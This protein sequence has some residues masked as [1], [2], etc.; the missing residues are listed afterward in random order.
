MEAEFNINPK[1]IKTNNKTSITL[2]SNNYYIS[3]IKSLT[4]KINNEIENIT[5][6]DEQN[7]TS[8]KFNLT[9]QKE[10]T[11]QIIYIDDEDVS[12][13]KYIIKTKF[14]YHLEK[15]VY[16]LSSNVKQGFISFSLIVGDSHYDQK[17]ECEPVCSC[18]DQDGQ[19]FQCNLTIDTSPIN[20][21]ITFDDDHFILY[22][23]SYEIDKKENYI[24][25]EGNND[26]I[27]II[28]Y[29]F[30]ELDDKYF[31]IQINSHIQESIKE[32]TNKTK[33]IVTINNFNNLTLGTY[34]LILFANN[35]NE[36]K[37]DIKFNIIKNEIISYLDHIPNSGKQTIKITTNNK[38]QTIYINKIILKKNSEE[39]IESEEC[40][41][42]KE[43]EY[44]LKCEIN[45]ISKIKEEEEKEEEEEE[46][47]NQK[48]DIYFKNICGKEINSNRSLY[49]GKIT[50]E[51]FNPE[52]YKL[53]TENQEFVLT[54]TPLINDI[55]NLKIGLKNSTQQFNI[56]KKDE[57]KY[58]YIE[59]SPEFN[60]T[61]NSYNLSIIDNETEYSS[62]I[63]LLLYEN[64]IELSSN[65][66]YLFKGE[67]LSYKIYLKKEIF[68]E[69]ITSIK[70][71][72]EVIKYGTSKEDE[73]YYILIHNFTFVGNSTFI[74][75]QKG[76]EQSI[77][78][79]LYEINY[80]PTF[81]V[82]EKKESSSITIDYEI[83]DELKNFS[84]KDEN[85]TIYNGTCV[86]Y[87]NSIRCTYN[88]DIN[89][90]N[91]KLFVGQAGESSQDFITVHP[92]LN[93]TEVCQDMDNINIT[94]EINNTFRD[95]LILYLNDNAFNSTPEIKP[96]IFTFNKS[97]SLP[98]DDYP[99]YA[100]INNENNKYKIGDNYT[101]SLYKKREIDFTNKTLYTRHEQSLKIEFGEN[102]YND[103][104]KS[105][106][107][108]S[109]DSN[110]LIESSNC[111]IDSENKT[112]F[113][114]FDLFNT[115][116]GNYNVY[117]NAKC[118]EHQ[119][120]S[121]ENTT[122]K[123]ENAILNIIIKS[124]ENNWFKNDTKNQTITIYYEN[125]NE[126]EILIDKVLLINKNTSQNYT[127]DALQIGNNILF[128][129]S[130]SENLKEDTYSII[131]KS[132]NDQSLPS[133][134]DN[135][136]YIY[137]EPFFTLK[138]LYYIKTNNQTIK[139]NTNSNID[140]IKKMYL[141]ENNTFIQKDKEFSLNVSELNVSELNVSEFIITPYFTIKGDSLNKTYY[142]NSTKD[143]NI[144]I[145][146]Y[147]NESELYEISNN[148]CNYYNDTDFSVK[149]K[150]N[151]SNFPITKMKIYL[152]NEKNNKSIELKE[153]KNNEYE[154]EYTY[155][156]KKDLSDLNNT[157]VKLIISEN[158]DI[159]YYISQK[160]IS[161]TDFTYDN[162]LEYL[163]D[164]DSFII[165]NLTCNLSTA[166]I[167][168]EKENQS[169]SIKLIFES[170]DKN[171]ATY[172]F[173][174]LSADSY[175]LG[176]LKIYN[177]VSN[178]FL[179]KI[180]N[181]SKFD[182]TLPSDLSLSNLEI[183]I[184]N[185]N[186][187]F[188]NELIKEIRITKKGDN[189]TFIYSKDS[190]DT[191][192][193]LNDNIFNFTIKNYNQGDIYIIN[194]IGIDKENKKEFTENNIIG[195][196]FTIPLP[197]YIFKNGENISVS[198]IILHF[199][200]KKDAESNLNKIKIDNK[201]IKN[202]KI[203]EENVTCEYQFEVECKEHNVT[204]EDNEVKVY[205]SIYDILEGFCQTLYDDKTKNKN[206][207]ILI[208]NP[209]PSIIFTI[210]YNNNNYELIENKY[211]IP[212][213]D[214]DSSNTSINIKYNDIVIKNSNDNLT[215]YDF[216]KIDEIEGNLVN[217]TISSINLTFSN[218]TKLEKYYI[219]YNDSKQE[220]YLKSSSFTKFENSSKYNLTFN[221]SSITIK[222]GEYDLC[223]I[224]DCENY[225]KAKR[226]IILSDQIDASMN[227]NYIIYE[228]DKNKT[229]SI[230]ISGVSKDLI[231]VYYNNEKKL[232][233]S[234]STELY[235]Y[236]EYK[237][238]NI[239]NVKFYYKLN[240]IKENI[241][242]LKVVNNYSDL[243]KF[244]NEIPQCSYKNDDLDLV[245]TLTKVGEFSFNS[246]EM[247][248]IKTSEK[249]I[250]FEKNNNV[251]T[252]KKD[253]IKSL[254]KNGNYKIIITENK[255][256]NDVLYSTN[257]E[258][259][260]IIGE[261]YYYKNEIEFREVNCKPEIKAIFNLDNNNDEISYNLLCNDI[262]DNILK[263]NL[264]ND[265]NFG[266]YSFIS[267]DKKIIDSLISNSL[268]E[269]DF[270]VQSK[271][272][273]TFIFT[274]TNNFYFKE[275]QSLTVSQNNSKSNEF[276]KGINLTVEDEFI[277][278][279]LDTSNI[280]ISYTITKIQT[281]KGY[282]IIKIE[283]LSNQYQIIIEKDAFF[284]TYN[285]DIEDEVTIKFKPDL[286]TNA[287]NQI[288]INNIDSE[289]ERNNSSK[290]LICKFTLPN[291]PR[292]FDV[293]FVTTQ[294]KSSATIYINGYDL[295]IYDCKKPKINL[296]IEAPLNLYDLELCVDEKDI[297]DE[298]IITK[299]LKNKI[300][301]FDV[302]VDSYSTN[303]SIKIN[304]KYILD[305]P[306][307]IETTINVEKISAS[308]QVGWKNQIIEIKL[309]SSILKEII[310]KIL[311]IESPSENDESKAIASTSN[312]SLINNQNV[313]RC[314]I[315]IINY[316]IDTNK[317]YYLYYNNICNN[318][319]NS[320]QQI[321]IE[322]KIS[323]EKVKGTM[324]I[325]KKEDEIELIFSTNIIVSQI[326]NVTLV[327]ENRKIISID[328]YDNDNNKTNINCLFNIT[329]VEPGDYQV[330]SFIYKSQEYEVDKFIKIQI[331][332]KEE[333]CREGTVK[334][335]NDCVI[336][337]DYDD[338]TNICINNEN[339]CNEKGK[340]I[341]Y[342][343]SFKC[344][345]Y[346][347]WTGIYCE[348]HSG[349]E[350]NKIE[351]LID[352]IIKSSDSMD[353]MIVI[354][355]TNY[356]IK[357]NN[358]KLNKTITNF[359]TQFYNQVK[360]LIKDFETKGKDKNLL[361]YYITLLDTAIFFKSR[362]IQ[363]QR[364]I[365]RKVIYRNLKEE[366]EDA[367]I[368]KLKM[369]KNNIEIYIK[370]KIEKSKFEPTVF[371][372][373]EDPEY[374]EGLPT[375]SFYKYIISSNYKTSYN[376]LLKISNSNFELKSCI[377]IVSN[378]KEV[379][380]IIVLII[381]T[382]EIANSLL[383][384]EEETSNNILG[385]LYDYS[386]DKKTLSSEKMSTCTEEGIISF[387]LFDSIDY[388]KYFYYYKRNIDIFN[389]NDSAFFPCYS[390]SKFDWDL[391]Q[392]MRMK[393]I[394]AGKI[395][396]II[397]E[398]DCLYNGINEETKKIEFICKNIG[399]LLSKGITS[400]LEIYDLGYD[401][402][403]DDLPT[404]CPKMIKHVEKNIG[405][406][407][408]FWGF[409]L[410]I[411]LSIINILRNNQ[412][413]I[414]INDQL[415]SDDNERV[416]EM[417]DLKKNENDDENEE[418]VNVNYNVN[419]DNF[420]SSIKNNFLELHPLITPFRL[421]LLSDTLLSSW[422]LFYNIF[423]NLGFN[424]LY[425]TN[426]MF[427][428]RIERDYRDNFFYP[429]RYEYHRIILAQVTSFGL[430]LIVRLI[431]LITLNKRQI[432]INEISS[433]EDNKN[434]VVKNYQKGNWIKKII[435]LI[436]ILGLDVFFFYYCMGFCAVY[437]NAQFGW[438][439]SGIW[440]MIFN[441][442]IY[443]PFYIFV[444]SIIES[445]GG[446]K[447]AYYMKRL[448]IF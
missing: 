232:E 327:K 312:C 204:I 14:P 211:I 100:Q 10:E 91:K 34:D 126:N 364:Q 5:Y 344:E 23:V 447:I 95:S 445:F 255:D 425:F 32:E 306:E 198:Q 289:C 140:M 55:S 319:I 161:F 65:F 220:K 252:L 125:E 214:L 177:N 30:S 246:I 354:K 1:T 40:E 264:P 363:I 110:E 79:N 117:Y 231:S 394:F 240:N 267:N 67:I 250:L 379:D 163:Y 238:T 446:G 129:I 192:F 426:T 283:I 404:L 296:Y 143:I 82:V 115:T 215:F 316:N 87:G 315:D 440:A 266:N 330:K 337:E 399:Q 245:T 165:S 155:S 75:E 431:N 298:P 276:I 31:K 263:C 352:Y 288:K 318:L 392:D 311:L 273:N 265:A 294:Y 149:F 207:N 274:S 133:T 400:T 374:N 300:I 442:F 28:F 329:K 387:S 401:N 272:E 171:N 36:E 241:G 342:K 128:N 178:I 98:V 104:I 406:W 7:F 27:N 145:T 381:S 417:Q 331:E 169:E 308:L 370:E 419:S 202:C 432:I 208:T 138:Q 269:A 371:I 395:F 359:D 287:E 369:L 57:K 154:Y 353:L 368:D 108:E 162:N 93:F 284:Y 253:H 430:T 130:S 24:C 361:S 299:Q 18:L 120:L 29:S 152:Y 423:N 132:G 322:R 424:S 84:L 54:M 383:N 99:I 339:I 435:T 35:Q 80:S 17:P 281:N 46:E 92:S 270:K 62:E 170:Y 216:I 382:K 420:S 113:C 398:N 167:T 190:N 209:L 44:N 13:N 71:N 338:Y 350:V 248:L 94:L 355:E 313:L 362:N 141:D 434:E 297:F 428:K 271:E 121:K 41:L 106:I 166:N 427:R 184:I 186:K 56:N 193:E 225:V 199:R 376:R 244:E 230:R 48:F 182:L 191:K 131:L 144:N 77:N 278:F 164:I 38:N 403:L 373:S 280:S 257:Y 88:V 345:C 51:S 416:S 325:Q 261:E 380:K 139:I 237:I 223:Y 341:N 159:N 103:Q 160:L 96:S 118:I 358:N 26:D 134:E 410:F 384:S 64:D 351:K 418:K 52:F 314:F 53:K 58:Y 444:I 413:Q 213:E 218:E 332:S 107:L 217:S 59:I 43:S 122:L 268:L 8:L 412:S 336:P 303:S 176:N 206:I 343:S 200:S 33:Q 109:I 324:K 148:N 437:I 76:K 116:P 233:K 74:I 439:Y 112:I 105:I 25:K 239:E 258:Y 422:I 414:I 221:L 226:I 388:D 333:L 174:D 68:N 375:L 187:D 227:R 309:S 285:A 101:I 189:Q 124:L 21:N 90:T 335:D 411:T 127:F 85:E 302:E 236:Y 135:M 409:V 386:Q 347:G 321:S 11:C 179:S 168:F 402:H 153:K 367:E 357:Q 389:K 4:I 119:K 251:F 39:M 78:Y 137:S 372:D 247:Y 323:L 156:E 408:F 229:M 60:I 360:Q 151:N 114:N 195:Q 20:I 173:K 37:T 407:V 89:E 301:Y 397:E 50:L 66:D 61:P 415:T 180:I 385:L 19:K 390:N 15:E 275:V 349:K 111:T 157:K 448:F 219:K 320:N 196:L 378:I 222:S 224:D 97:I 249:Q 146:I 210:E 443:G 188:Y 305:S 393:E 136:I 45:F 3:S 286:P 293:E 317:K 396:K 181:N 197:Y 183:K 441:W 73:K 234:K 158:N 304:D 212:N 235:N 70:L 326:K 242:T 433:S 42:T 334:Q 277:S 16:F 63:K 356:L 102:I 262:K 282:R 254:E 405:F 438:F 205:V 123:I 203:K 291:K 295:K 310:Q 83:N 290:S 86:K 12:Q 328:C 185:T 256:L 279:E 348:T 421:S 365:K 259:T 436:F 69:Q 340:C 260:S 307:K 47:E 172:K 6:F 243:F 81:F 2:S 201:E 377:N 22:V 346:D 194:S 9:L 391:P 292:D 366:T 72:E 228:N 49:V 147:E 142:I 175:G 429:M 150:L